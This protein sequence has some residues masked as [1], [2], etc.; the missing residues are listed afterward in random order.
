MAYAA[1]SDRVGLAR[2]SIGGRLTQT[3]VATEPFACVDRW[4][5]RAC[6]CCEPCV[7]GGSLRSDQGL[8]SVKLPSPE[9]FVDGVSM[10]RLYLI[11]SLML[12]TAWLLWSACERDDYRTTLP[13]RPL[14]GAAREV[15]DMPV[16]LVSPVDLA[17]PA[18]D[19][20]FVPQDMPKPLDQAP[21]SD[22]G[23]SDAGASDAG[24]SDGA[25]AG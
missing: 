22:A 9:L 3:T 2:C 20:P 21:T 12:A 13:L 1:Q 4:L 11:C 25:L 18:M 14:D 16:D 19:M 17:V 23:A 6:I 10:R 8:S 7:L 15:T 24:R 5:W